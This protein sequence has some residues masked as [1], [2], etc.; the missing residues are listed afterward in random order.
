MEKVTIITYLSVFIGI[1]ASLSID[2]LF[3]TLTRLR[4]KG[5]FLDWAVIV[6]VLHA[7]LP[8]ASF[9]FAWFAGQLDESADIAVGLIGFGLVALYLYEEFCEKIG[10]E[11]KTQLIETVGKK[12][13]VERKDAGVLVLGTGV[14]ID[15]F[16]FGPTLIATMDQLNLTLTEAYLAFAVI[17]VTVFTITLTT[18]ALPS[19]FRLLSKWC[20]WQV[21]SELAIVHFY[22]DLAVFSVIGGFGLLS[23]W[24]TT[25]FETYITLSI[26]AS[27]IFWSVLFVIFRNE[28]M[29]SECREAKEAIE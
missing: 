16:L 22:A 10:K 12:L 18:L 27:T 14:S 17:G 7:L 15:S 2:V 26:I 13:G 21:E 29:E 3:A 20:G 19:I 11:S 23:L 9:T 6:A 25:G 8:A 28:L 1:G 5:S 4:E 24:G